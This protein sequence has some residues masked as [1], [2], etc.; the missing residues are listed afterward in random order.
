MPFDGGSP[1]SGDNLVLGALRK[2]RENIA[3]PDRWV[4]K[5]LFN[6]DL[7]QMCALGALVKS[8]SWMSRESLEAIGILTEIVRGHGFS[9]VSQFNDAPGTTHGDVMALFDKAIER[10]ER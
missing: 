3:T 1:P 7:A 9:C 8:T 10:A 6:N 4:K 5:S 2:A